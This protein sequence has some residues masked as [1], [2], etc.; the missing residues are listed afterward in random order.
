MENYFWFLIFFSSVFFYS[1]SGVIVMKN[2][3]LLT[4]HDLHLKK[5]AVDV[6]FF[7]VYIV[8]TV[9]LS[10]FNYPRIST[11]IYFALCCSP[12]RNRSPRA[13]D[14]PFSTLVK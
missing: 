4:V 10:K 12:E 3:Y 1:F 6:I 11:F 2:V 7:I 8:V 13:T 5:K 9:H 14:K